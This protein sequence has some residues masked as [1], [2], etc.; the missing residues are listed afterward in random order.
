MIYINLCNVTTNDNLGYTVL[1]RPNR[2]K[3]SDQCTY[4]YI[5]IVHSCPYKV[6]THLIACRLMDTV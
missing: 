3:Q 2:S 4:I 1:M 5:Q 6:I